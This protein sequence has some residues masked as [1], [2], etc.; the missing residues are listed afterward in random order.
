MFTQ[1]HRAVGGTHIQGLESGGNKCPAHGARVPQ[2][3][4][5]LTGHLQRARSAWAGAKQCW[6]RAGLGNSSIPAGREMK[7]LF[8]SRP[9]SL[10]CSS[11]PALRIC[12]LKVC[13]TMLTASRLSGQA[14]RSSLVPACTWV[15]MRKGS[16][17]A[18]LQAAEAGSFTANVICMDITHERQHASEHE[19]NLIQHIVVHVPPS[20]VPVRLLLAKV[21]D[22]AYVR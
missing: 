12:G 1:V 20:S 16:I 13:M 10:T 17:R 11:S 7:A 9:C 21:A 15:M 8:R 18:S 4:V 6:E 2:A 5:G 22:R 19:G 3:T 14:H